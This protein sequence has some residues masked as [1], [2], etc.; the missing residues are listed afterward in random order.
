MS[1]NYLPLDVAYT[2]YEQ[3]VNLLRHKQQI[4]ITFKAHKSIVTNQADLLNNLA[5]CT[6]FAYQNTNYYNLNS[7]Q[8]AIL[9]TITATAKTENVDSEQLL[10]AQI[11]LLAIA[12]KIKSLAAGQSVVNI[13]T[14]KQLTNLYNQQAL[15]T[16]HNNVLAQT[17]ANQIVLAK[18]TAALL[19]QN[20]F[21][22]NQQLPN[23]APLNTAYSLV[24]IS[25]GIEFSAACLLYGVMQAELLAQWI[26]QCAATDN[27]NKDFTT[28][29]PTIANI[30]QLV[31]A[32]INAPQ[33]VAVHITNN[34]AKLANIQNAGQIIAQSH[35]LLNIMVSLVNY[36]V[37]LIN[38]S[39][40]TA[41]QQ[42]TTYSNSLQQYI[43][44][45]QKNNLN[46][47]VPESPVNT[48]NTSFGKNTYAEVNVLNKQ[49]LPAIQ[50][51][52]DI[53]LHH[54]LLLVTC[55]ING[56]AIEINPVLQNMVQQFVQQIGNSTVPFTTAQTVQA[57][58]F[59][60][61][62]NLL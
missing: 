29:L 62:N 5:T 8:Q 34:T 15:P 44:T 51:A 45:L 36:L 38:T 33:N 59:L 52:Q 31:L 28:A 54:F 37:Q 56:Q 3:L 61:T 9:N 10:P 2:T 17:N 40:V 43:N 6:N 12:L 18:I 47:L 20:N 57:K 19:N 32:I 16:I 24:A 7:L 27:K 46:Y 60:T 50:N 42:I 39:A 26:T 23:S 48:N 4:S 13:E 11:I 1:Y 30:K 55:F 35:V 22:N 49:L 53:I 21:L 58:Q 41:G 25:T 14:V